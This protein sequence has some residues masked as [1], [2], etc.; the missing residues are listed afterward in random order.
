MQHCVLRFIPLS[1]NAL[2][3]LTGK[4]YD[5]HHETVS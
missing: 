4:G 2:F 3:R 5:S 1:I